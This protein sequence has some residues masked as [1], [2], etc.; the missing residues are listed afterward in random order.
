M[1]LVPG[2]GIIKMCCQPALW[3]NT[4]NP[5]LEM[6]GQRAVNQAFVMDLRDGFDALLARGNAKRKRKRFRHQEKI[7]A[8]H[9]GYRLAMPQS[10]SQCDEMLA[11]FLAQKSARLQ[12]RGL[13]DVFASH[14]ARDFLAELVSKSVRAR[15]PLLRLFGLEIGGKVRA[16]LGGGV[17]QN[18]MSA[19][20]TSIAED[21]LAALSPGEMLLYLVAE[22]CAR[23][24]LTHI[25]LGAG[26][27]RYKRSW[28]DGT[29]EMFDVI[30]PTS[31]PGLPL[32]VGSR[33]ALT[34]KRMVREHG[35]LW[36]AVG[37][38]RGLRRRLAG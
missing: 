16:V 26:E 15:E 32:A 3:N 4:A 23:E 18:R 37:A 20:F 8:A 33:T 28:C 1:A 5:M 31:L 17:H 38:L 13:R 36:N 6:G 34:I 11:I 21:E 24:G 22:Q 14:H 35:G 30:I 9:G 12:T 19:Y 27:E 7:A 10:I 25:D 29:I 2:V